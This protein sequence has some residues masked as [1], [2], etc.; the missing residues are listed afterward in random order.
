MKLLGGLEE[1]IQLALFTTLVVQIHWETYEIL[2]SSLLFNHMLYLQMV[3]FVHFDI[4]WSEKV[5]NSCN[6]I[7]LDQI[8]IGI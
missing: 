8:A 4:S 1:S 5:K 2:D 7:A 3:K 6:L